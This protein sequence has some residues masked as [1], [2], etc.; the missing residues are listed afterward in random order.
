[1]FPVR[2][3]P[4]G[5]R[6][7]MKIGRFF[8][9][10]LGTHSQRELAR[11]E[12]HLDRIDA[13]GATLKARTGGVRIPIAGISMGAE[14]AVSRIAGGLFGSDITFAAGKTATAPG[15]IPIGKLRPAMDLIYR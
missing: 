3:G 2:P 14:G 4:A 15:Q 12:S 8:K 5:P 10:A 6:D 7:E 13:L 1:M 11:A 9:K